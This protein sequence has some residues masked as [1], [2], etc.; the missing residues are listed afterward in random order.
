[1]YHVCYDSVH[2]CCALAAAVPADNSSVA[3]SLVETFYNIVYS[4][5][6][7]GFQQQW[8]WHLL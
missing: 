6:E 4:V 7:S 8:Q 2:V 3:Q 5:D 1:M